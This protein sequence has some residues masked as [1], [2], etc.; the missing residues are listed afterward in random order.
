MSNIAA[1]TESRVISAKQLPM[2]LRE[3]RHWPTLD[4]F[5]A[6]EEK[7]YVATVLHA[8]RNDKVAAAKTLGVDVGALG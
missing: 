4:E 3:P 8:T 5:L 6:A 2:R 1:N 7:H